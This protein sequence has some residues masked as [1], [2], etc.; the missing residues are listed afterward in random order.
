[1]AICSLSLMILL[2][3]TSFSPERNYKIFSKEILN[4]T[5]LNKIVLSDQVAWLALR[6][7]LNENQLIGMRP[8]T[9]ISKTMVVDFLLDTNNNA[10][11]VSAVVY[12]K[13]REERYI[14][15][16]PLFK[17]LISRA[18]CNKK[19]IGL[20]LPLQVMVLNCVD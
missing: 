19:Q 5:N 10:S 8:G 6:P 13:G 20:G 16:Y 3:F 18:N 7:V 4:N 12:H 9:G 14:K 15:I 17:E 11:K 2:A 1:M